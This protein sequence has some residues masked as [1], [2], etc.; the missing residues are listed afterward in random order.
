VS[1]RKLKPPAV[2][3]HPRRFDTAAR[4]FYNPDVDSSPGVGMAGL[5]LAGL[6]ALFACSPAPQRTA[7][8]TKRAASESTG[9]APT[10]LMLDTLAHF[11]KLSRYGDTGSELESISESQCHLLPIASM[12]LREAFPR[13]QF[14]QYIHAR[15]LQQDHWSQLA[16]SRNMIAVTGDTYYLMPMEF[17]RLLFATGQLLTD[18]N[19]A[20]LA[21]AYVVF[22][23]II[24]LGRNSADP[25]AIPPIAILDA[26]RLDRVTV[27]SSG[28][29]DAYVKIRI[30]NEVQEHYIERRYGQVRSAYMKNPHLEE[31]MKKPPGLNGTILVLGYMPDHPALV[32]PKTGKMLLGFP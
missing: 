18:S 22:A 8:E 12:E 15:T 4:E 5:V 11:A 21:K 24:S 10:D 25:S 2:G 9:Q 19:I 14:Y 29:Y 6:L 1:L 17:N 16:E 27:D 13:V 28:P 3:R 7:P 30:G 31:D 32:N 20:M 26:K 23:A